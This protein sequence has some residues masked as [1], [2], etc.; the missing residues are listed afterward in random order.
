V[1]K[2]E[3]TLK[4]FVQSFTHNSKSNNPHR[5]RRPLIHINDDDDRD[6]DD[7]DVKRVVYAHVF[8]E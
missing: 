4:L 6:G 3:K 1:T 5:R 7:D 8:N 2:G